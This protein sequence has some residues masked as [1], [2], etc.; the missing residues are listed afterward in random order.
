MST[1]A[2]VAHFASPDDLKKRIADLEAVLF[3]VREAVEFYVDVVDG[4]DGPA[5]NRAMQAVALIDGVLP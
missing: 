5:P 4:D 1:P 2:P 3:E